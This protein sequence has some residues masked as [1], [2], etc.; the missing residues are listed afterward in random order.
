VKIKIK[1]QSQ[2]YTK[3]YFL[4]CMFSNLHVF[5][6][7]CFQIPFYFREMDYVADSSDMEI[8]LFKAARFSFWE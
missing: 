8:S 2:E 3:I 5:K 1:M 4:A 6:L 7:L